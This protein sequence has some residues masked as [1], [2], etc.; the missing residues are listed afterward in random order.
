MREISALRGF[1]HTSPNFRCQCVSNYSTTISILLLRFCPTNLVNRFILQVG[2]FI[3]NTFEIVQVLFVLN[4]SFFF[5]S[6]YLDLVL[7]FP[8]VF[9]YLNRKIFV[10]INGERNQ[11][12]KIRQS[13]RPTIIVQEINIIYPDVTTSVFRFIVK[14]IYPTYW[15]CN[16]EH[17]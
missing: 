10:K 6:F 1:E 14:R 12:L 7:I 5:F 11:K 15:L 3:S 16:T 4:S 17:Y 13:V 2:R 8:C 9:V